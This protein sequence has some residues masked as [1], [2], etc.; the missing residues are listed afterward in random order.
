MKL[1]HKLLLRS[2]FSSSM[3]IL[4]AGCNH[5]SSNEQNLEVQKHTVAQQGLPV[6][7][8]S[9]DLGSDFK[10]IAYGNGI[11]MIVGSNGGIYTSHNAINWTEQIDVTDINLNAVAYNSKYKA[12]YAVGD[13]SKIFTSADGVSWTE[14]KELSQI[15]DLNSISVLSDGNQVIGGGNG[16]LFE[17]TVTADSPEDH[18]VVLRK[19]KSG[20]GDDNSM[21]T[22]VANSPTYMVAGSSSSSLDT[23]KS[24]RPSSWTYS[25]SNNASGVTDLAYDSKAGL[26]TSLSKDGYLTSAD[27]TAYASTWSQPASI[28]YPDAAS[29]KAGIKANSI[30]SDSINGYIF[31]AG[32]GGDNK[33]TFIRYTKNAASW[34]NESMLYPANTGSLNKVRC[35]TGAPEH[36]CIAV[37]DKKAIV[38]IKIKND[39]VTPEP[40]DI[41]DPKI[42]AFDPVDGDTQVKTSPLM[43]VTFNK[44]VVNVNNS[45][46]VLFQ[47][48]IGS[49]E[50]VKLDSFEGS[51]P[52]EDSYKFKPA[53][54]LKSFTH[55][56]IEFE[57]G[58]QDKYGK[59]IES[60]IFNFTT[61]ETSYPT[62]VV[63]TPPLDAFA[64]NNMPLIEALFSEPVLHVNTDNVKLRE[65]SDKGP[66]VV[67]S[68]PAPKNDSGYLFA[69]TAK[70][71]SMTKYCI[72]FSSGITDF[73]GNKLEETPSCFTTGDFTAPTVSMKKPSD[74]QI[75]VALDTPIE[76]QFNKSVVGVDKASVILH[77]GSSSGAVVKL[78]SITGGGSNYTAIPEQSLKLNTSYYLA[79]S[80]EIKDAGNEDNPLEP[81]VF[82]FKTKSNSSSA[83]IASDYCIY[84]YTPGKGLTCVTKPELSMQDIVYSKAFSRYVAVG[85]YGYG[86]VST[87]G[88]NWKEIVVDKRENTLNAIAMLN[89]YDQN[90]VAVGENGAILASSDMGQTWSVRENPAGN[91]NLTNIYSDG[92]QFWIAVDGD[93]WLHSADGG[94]TWKLSTDLLKLPVTGA[95]NFMAYHDGGSYSIVGGS[96]GLVYVSENKQSW[97]P[98]TSVLSGGVS[99]NA[100]AYLKNSGVRLLFG[101]DNK[102]FISDDAS[103]NNWRKVTELEAYVKEN[104]IRAQVSTSNSEVYVISNTGIYVS[105]NGVN[106]NNTGKI[107]VNKDKL[108]G[109]A[110]VE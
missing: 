86:Y 46:V 37:G 84:S 23:N 7:L 74:A 42:T 97:V 108:N 44:A 59:H 55:Y 8:L 80:S 90:V 26:F 34:A 103:N 105:K 62:V 65:G 71:K 28:G 96:N 35:F 92:S 95:Q 58:I 11:Y 69:P 94:Q 81:I 50:E 76:F 13:N 66:A 110:I 18:K 30:A 98:Q 14:Y 27:A 22:A 68:E 31:V 61:D 101:N 10:D 17:V 82:S 29:Y 91:Q 63:V 3:L 47:D 60:K 24:F 9:K 54:K 20:Q 21:V 49:A 85:E 2:L 73:Y 48:H 1:K 93:K 15:V 33:N 64:V 16:S 107:T 88:T 77:E 72:V 109:I 67:I 53:H 52:A 100:Y 45:N 104:Y 39:E 102:A 43:E 56:Q 38:I 79:L 19:M 83:V 36:M 89:S 5:G 75:D 99:L 70:L 57:S 41:N 78:A 40:I 87:N 51:R 32:G 106:W 4:M 25:G 6:G 12:F